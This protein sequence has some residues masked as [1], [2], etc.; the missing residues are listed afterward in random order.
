[1][2]IISAALDPQILYICPANPLLAA[3]AVDMHVAEKHAIL[4]VRSSIGVC[5]GLATLE[6]GKEASRRQRWE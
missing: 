1:M 5:L 6:E 2:P 4:I 3:E